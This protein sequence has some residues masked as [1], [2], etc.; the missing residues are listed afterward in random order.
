M[1]KPQSGHHKVRATEA[2]PLV[3]WLV[4]EQGRRVRDWETHCLQSV[5]PRVLGYRLLQLGDW[6]LDLQAL[7]GSAMLR[8]WVLSDTPGL[9]GQLVGDMQQLPVASNCL[10]AVLLPHSLEL[11]NNPRA[12]LREV[13]RVLCNRG[14][15]ILLGFNP[16][17]AWH[18]GQYWPLR[19][20][21]PYPGVKQLFTRGRVCDW[22]DLLDFEVEQQI[23]YGAV[24]PGLVDVSDYQDRRRWLAP[25]GPAYMIFAR[26]RVLPVTPVRERWRRLPGLGPAVLPEA[27]LS[28]RVV[29]LRSIHRT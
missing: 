10:D 15:I 8:H 2:D 22:L 14:Q 29:Q 6:D 5:M 11:T 7:V 20:A 26:K 17:S 9:C 13:D 25:L 21:L 19:R 28:R 3:S 12:L 27:R 24:L 4:S 1:Q 23:H 18:A 16:L